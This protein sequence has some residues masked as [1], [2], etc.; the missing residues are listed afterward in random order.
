MRAKKLRFG[1]IGYIALFLLA[2]ILVFY[3]CKATNQSMPSIVVETEF[4]GE[5]SLGGSNWSGFYC[6]IGHGIGLY[7]AEASFH[8]PAMEY[9]SDGALYGRLYPTGYK[10]YRVYER[11]DYF[12]YL[13]EADLHHVC[14]F[15]A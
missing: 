4:V 7:G 6:I 8:R 13:H 9:G 2:G 15:G 5:Y 1:V 14:R 3:L 12:Q 10:G 11:T